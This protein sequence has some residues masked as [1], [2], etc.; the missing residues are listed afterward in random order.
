MAIVLKAKDI[1]EKNIIYLDEEAS[2][3]NAVKTMVDKN[4]GSVAVK[5]NE[6]FVGIITERDILS[7]VTAEKRNL[8][9]TKLRD[10]MSSPLITVEARASLYEISKKLVKHNIKRIF[11]EE[12]G[13]IVG[14]ISQQDL[15]R[16]IMNTFL[17][18]IAI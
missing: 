4:I 18:L 15:V 9:T 16:E 14:L 17:S 12:D 1:M 8:E 10:V 11:V 5:K 7:R 13:E 3:F 6:K 2:V